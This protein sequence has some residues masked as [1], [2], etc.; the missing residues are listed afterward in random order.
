MTSGNAFNFV[1]RWNGLAHRA[2]GQVYSK[3]FSVMGTGGGMR[4]K[5]IK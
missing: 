5:G 4:W 3:G 2:E 1:S